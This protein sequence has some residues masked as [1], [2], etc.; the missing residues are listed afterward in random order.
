M[1]GI[2][3]VF[4][5]KHDENGMIIMNK[6]AKLEVIHILLSFSVHDNMRL[7]QMDVKNIYLNG[8]I[9]EEAYVKQPLKFVSDVFQNH[10]FEL[11]KALYGLK[12]A[13]CA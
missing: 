5:N 4:K 13:P 8:I 9:N 2:K 3:L 10:V 6:Q 1:I 12:Q 7:Y 11:K